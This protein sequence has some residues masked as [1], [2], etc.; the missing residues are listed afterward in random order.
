MDSNHQEGRSLCRL[1]A[2]FII[3]QFLKAGLRPGLFLLLFTIGLLYKAHY[4]LCLLENR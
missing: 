3:L 4:R 1:I 2:A